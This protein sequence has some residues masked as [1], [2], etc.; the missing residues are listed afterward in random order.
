VLAK[1]V[2]CITQKRRPAFA[3]SINRNPLLLMMNILPKRLQLW[4]IRMILK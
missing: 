3:Y 1:K 2:L 4:A